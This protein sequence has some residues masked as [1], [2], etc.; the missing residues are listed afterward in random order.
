MTNKLNC[1]AHSISKPEIVRKTNK[2]WKLKGATKALDNNYKGIA[3]LH[4]RGFT[5]K[6]IH[7]ILKQFGVPVDYNNLYQWQLRRF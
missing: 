6:Q 1:C 3:T 5:W 4:Q 7:A 2:G